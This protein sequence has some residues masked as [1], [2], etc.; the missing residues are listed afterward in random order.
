VNLLFRFAAAASPNL[1][2]RPVQ[3]DC[4]QRLAMTVAAVSVGI[5]ADLPLATP[6]ESNGMA[7]HG[8]SGICP[9]LMCRGIIAPAAD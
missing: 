2:T 3:P 8:P 1:L 6:L 7:F 9:A 4:G 5:I